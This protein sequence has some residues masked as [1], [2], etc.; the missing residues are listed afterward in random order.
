MKGK[1]VAIVIC[2]MF[3]LTAATTIASAMQVRTIYKD[4]YIEASGETG[5]QN[6]IKLGSVNF[7]WLI[8]WF[9]PNVTVT[10]YDSPGGQVL[11]KSSDG[12]VS[13]IWAT[14]LFFF[15]GNSTLTDTTLT[16]S[17]TAKAVFTVY[18][19]NWWLP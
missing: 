19:K 2:M 16:L 13:L 10:I 3:L 7:M 17:G 6:K 4:C 5:H 1:I 11:W 18:E 12:P 15:Q 9:Q 14:R 8:Q